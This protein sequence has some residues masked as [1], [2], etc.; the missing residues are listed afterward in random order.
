MGYQ[1]WVCVPPK[2][3]FLVFNSENVFVKTVDLPRNELR[4]QDKTELFQ[5]NFIHLI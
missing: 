1:P 2:A 5:L 4:N 3:L